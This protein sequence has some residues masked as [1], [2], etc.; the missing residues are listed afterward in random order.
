MTWSKFITWLF[1]I[2]L[3]YYAIA[4]L[5]DFMRGGNVKSPTGGDD[6]S[7][8]VSGLYQDSDLQMVEVEEVH[9]ESSSASVPSLS[10]SEESF[11]IQK[12]EKKKDSPIEDIYNNI[13]GIIPPV[14][15]QGLTLNEIIAS[16]RKGALAMTADINY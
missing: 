9:I 14:R 7:L 2:Y 5:I 3:A 1:L 4:F 13:G 6:D 11:E 10:S 15:T 16:A 12:V 8:D